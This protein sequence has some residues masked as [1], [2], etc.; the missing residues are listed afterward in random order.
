MKCIFIYNPVG[1]KGKI[2]KK[3]EYILHELRE[4]YEI[5]DCYATACAGDMT[6]IVKEVAGE[7]DAIVFAGGDGTVNEILQ[8][9]GGMEN[10][11]TL[12]YIPSG[13]VN[14]VAHSLKLPR[15]IKRALKI[16]KAGH[17]ERYDCMKVNDGYA[18]YVVAAG[19][20][21]GATYNTSQKQ[22]NNVGR[23]AY[24]LEGI[25]HNLKL[26]TFEVRCDAE[27]TTV[28]TEN[29]VLIAVINSK[30]VAGFRIDKRASLQDGQIEVAIVEHK[31]KGGI[32]KTLGS[33]FT[34]FGLFLLGYRANIRHITHVMGNAFD[35]ELA[36]DI[37][38]NIDGEKGS[39]G[40][41]RIEVVRKKVPFFVE[42]N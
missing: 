16:I 36:P 34:V 37:V 10:P 18:M 1:G 8:V 11:P 35:I 3:K 28:H 14:D 29:C 24:G 32:F 4:K 5:V 23:I 31:K 19:A 25:R 42:N 6:R 26:P 33:Y 2:A 22:K 21:T 9:I 15:S 13:T 7:Y 12:G 38:W 39:A 27:Q 30:Y 41:V 40:K 20:F 17:V